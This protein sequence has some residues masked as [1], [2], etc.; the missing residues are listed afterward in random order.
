M[1]LISIGDTK[2]GKS[3]IIK[4][5][6]EGRFVQ[7]YITTIGVDYGVKKVT[8]NGKKV[9]VNFFDLSGSSEYEEIR[10]PFLEDSQVIL[11]VFDL[12]NRESF[13]NLSKWEQLL[14]S[15]GVNL[16]EN[17]VFLLG[18]KSDLRSKEIDAAEAIGYAKKKGYE[19]FQTSASTG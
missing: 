16:K 18:N 2:T 13:N 17:A 6:C 4:R 5:Y 12:D 15:N 19:Y 11:L 1:Q 8:V 3:C 7:K 10:N 9:A 14:K